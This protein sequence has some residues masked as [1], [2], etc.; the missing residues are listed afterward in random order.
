MNVKG[1]CVGDLMHKEVQTVPESAPLVEAALLMHR[2]N[3][4]SLVV[5]KEGASDAFGILTRKDVVMALSSDVPG[6][7]PLLVKDVMTK[8][9]ITVA[10][11]LSIGQCLRLMRMAG[12]RRMPVESGGRLVG[13]L[14]NSDLFRRYVENLKP[15][16]K[17]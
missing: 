15:A 3:V 2:L 17:P 14:S 9:A 8:P 10:P 6:A 1:L 11:E 5:E 7:D 13:I 16:G 12:V 4:S